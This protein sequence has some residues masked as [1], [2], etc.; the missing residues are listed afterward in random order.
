MS[1]TAVP[2]TRD[3]AQ[4]FIASFHRHNR[5]PIGGLFQV[6]ASDGDR[7]VGVAMAGRPVARGLQDST[8]IEV[9]R[10]CVVDDAPKGTPS[11]LY[12]SLWRAARALG[13]RR[14]VTYTL[15]SES[16]ASLRGAGW[17]VIAELRGRDPDQIARQSRA[18]DWQPIYGQQKLRWEIS[19]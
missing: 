18:R 9:I 19:A 8:T 3:E 7:L 2:M 16:G 14:A 5:P 15:A 17:K 13:W 11:F 1:L 12:N 6:G 4:A 10:C